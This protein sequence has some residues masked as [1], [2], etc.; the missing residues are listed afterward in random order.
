MKLHFFLDKLDIREISFADCLPHAN[1]LRKEA[2]VM[3]REKFKTL[4][5]Q[6]FYILLCL[7]EERCGIEILDAVREMTGNRVRIGF[8]T[9]YDLLEQFTK[10]GMIFETGTE[11]RRRKLGQQSPRGKAFSCRS[12]KGACVIS[13]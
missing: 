7:Y 11:G 2:L 6:M 4:T 3:P 12:S 8:G 1:P 10:E 5:E 13:G 9:L